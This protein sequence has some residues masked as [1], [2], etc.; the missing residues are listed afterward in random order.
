MILLQK[1]LGNAVAFVALVFVS[2][3]LL[4]ATGELW[5]VK[6]K[7]AGMPMDMPA[8]KLCMAKEAIREKD[9]KPDGDCQ[10]T[11]FQNLGPNHVKFSF[12]C[13][14]GNSG[15]MDIQRDDKTFKQSMTM[16]QGGR[17]MNMNSEGKNTGQACDPDAGK[18]LAAEA[19]QKAE[20]TMG[21]FCETGAKTLSSLR[22]FYPSKPA[23]NNACDK[24][25]PAYCAMVKSV[26]AEMNTDS[27]A[28]LKHSAYGRGYNAEASES[29]GDWRKAVT[30]CGAGNPV[31][32]QKNAC[33][34]AMKS[35]H[36]EMAKVY[37]KADVEPI[38]KRECVGRNYSTNPIKREY[39][40]LCS[41]FRP[42]AS[43]GAGYAESAAPKTGTVEIEPPKA[44]TAPAEKAPPTE[45]PGGFAKKLKGLFGL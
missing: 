20:V 40:G 43:D 15:D 25:R 39:R 5:E 3:S 23:K 8:T 1:S 35:N 37:C 11:N 33:A 38:A 14:G 36:W 31:D 29:M 28:F 41:G 42:G 18:K 16:N 17:K 27:K 45:A 13:K 10:T 24:Y 22:T 2:S 12:T 44:V 30:L 6:M 32:I 21:E 26:A 34:E 9:V 19:Q 4:A 7:M